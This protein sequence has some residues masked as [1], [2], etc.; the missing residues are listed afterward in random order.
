MPRHRNADADITTQQSTD[1]GVQMAPFEP[2]GETGPAATDVRTR[3]QACGACGG[4]PVDRRVMGILLACLPGRETSDGSM[5]SKLEPA[6]IQ[7]SNSHD[8][9]ILS[10]VPRP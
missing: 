4:Q 7:E 8:N 10:S 9:G 2:L 1:T 5:K 3:G 6:G